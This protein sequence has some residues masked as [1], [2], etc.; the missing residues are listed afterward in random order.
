MESSERDNLL[1][2]PHSSHYRHTLLHKL[3]AL[4]KFISVVLSFWLI[5]RVDPMRN[6]AECTALTT[7]EK[8]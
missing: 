7:L 8:P 5:N 6:I 2:R 1:M 4:K 3:D